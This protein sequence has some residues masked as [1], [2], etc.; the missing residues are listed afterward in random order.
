[1][2]DTLYYLIEK[3]KSKT[4]IERDYGLY[5]NNYNY[6]EHKT[7]EKLIYI[8]FDKKGLL[9][10]LAD[11]KKTYEVREYRINNYKDLYKHD[12]LFII[13]NTT[14]KKNMTY[15]C[16]SIY[17]MYYHL[18]ETILELKKFYQ[19]SI[20]IFNIEKVNTNI[21]EYPMTLIN[22]RQTDDYYTIK[23]H[24]FS[25]LKN[26]KIEFLYWNKKK[27]KYPNESYHDFENRLNQYKEYKAETKIIKEEN[28]KRRLE[29]VERKE[30]ERKEL[31]EQR[32]R[33]QKFLSLSVDQQKDLLSNY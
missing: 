12:K 7:I 28:E 30:R 6:K 16:I 13:F 3:I 4:I 19:F 23:L 31:I 14:F 29:E 9:K 10:Y 20:L 22:L 1:M 24:N 33:I 17:N 26:Y 5:E 27:I 11:E 32:E 18:D 2:Y 8:T 15:N 25:E 21:N